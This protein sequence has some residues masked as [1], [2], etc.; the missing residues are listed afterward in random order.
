MPIMG[1]LMSLTCISL[2][3]AGN[4]AVWYVEFLALHHWQIVWSNVIFLKSYNNV[5]KLLL[6]QFAYI[7]KVQGP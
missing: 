5:F 2:Q 1:P 7:V 4:N 6:T 3:L